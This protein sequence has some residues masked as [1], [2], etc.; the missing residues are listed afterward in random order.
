MLLFI[1]G[2]SAAYVLFSY[3]VVIVSLWWGMVAQQLGD[4]IVIHTS[5]FGGMVH[6]TKGKWQS[7]RS[8][9]F[10]MAVV[11]PSKRPVQEYNRRDYNTR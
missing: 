3:F 8:I 10:N 4:I 5:S 7:Y 11:T 9:T 1:Q 2:S 6:Y